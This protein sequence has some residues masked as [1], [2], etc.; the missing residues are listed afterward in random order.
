MLLIN[1]LRGETIMMEKK[2]E[3]EK[4]I[5]RNWVCFNCCCCCC[6]CC[7]WCCNKYTLLWIFMLLLILK[8][9]HLFNFIFDCVFNELHNMISLTTMIKTKTTKTWFYPMNFFMEFFM[10][11]YRWRRGLWRNVTKRTL[12]KKW[13]WR[14]K[15]I[16]CK[17]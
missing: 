9:I 14:S 5:E 11:I 13:N 3:M 7:L 1:S 6:Y 2:T 10:M 8:K 15:Q 17:L 4:Q 12:R 16:T